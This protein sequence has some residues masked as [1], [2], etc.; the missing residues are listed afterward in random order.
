[1]NLKDTTKSKDIFSSIKTRLCKKKLIL[2]IFR[3]L[4]DD[5]PVMM[6]NKKEAIQLLIDKIESNNKTAVEEMVYL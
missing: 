6:G 4:T 1:M 2:E 5:T 3:I